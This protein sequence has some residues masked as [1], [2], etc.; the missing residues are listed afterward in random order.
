MELDDNAIRSEWQELKDGRSPLRG[1]LDNLEGVVARYLG[2]LDAATSPRQRA[3]WK[4]SI[5][6]LR[7]Q[8]R[9]LIMREDD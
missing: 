1:T 3:H 7:R 2:Y 8:I 5:A 9:E 4:A 6:T